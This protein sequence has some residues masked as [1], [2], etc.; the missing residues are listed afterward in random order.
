MAAN[1]PQMELTKN[2]IQ[3]CSSFCEPLVLLHALL[4]HVLFSG[5]VMLV[6]LSCAM[7]SLTLVVYMCVIVWACIWNMCA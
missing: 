7:H 1:H 2:T 6:S 3:G 5:T 4:F